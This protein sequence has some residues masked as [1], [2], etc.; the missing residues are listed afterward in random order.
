[1]GRLVREAL[2]AV[3][4]ILPILPP[5]AEYPG[6]EIL[7]VTDHPVL[8]MEEEEVGPGLPVVQQAARA[9]AV[10]EGVALLRL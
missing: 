4:V 8:H 1:M 3:L 9:L 6:R 2:V 5:E 7:G 10:L